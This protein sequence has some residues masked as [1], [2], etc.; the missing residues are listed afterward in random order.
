MNQFFA[1]CAIFVVGENVNE[2]F[3]ML[4]KMVDLAKK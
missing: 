1:F 2:I 4:R 3:K